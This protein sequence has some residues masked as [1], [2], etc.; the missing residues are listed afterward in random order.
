VSLPGHQGRVACLAVSADGRTLVSAAWDKTIRVWDVQPPKERRTITTPYPD[1]YRMVLAP[2]DKTV[3]IPGYQAV[4]RWSLESGEPLP[5]WKEFDRDVYGLAASPDRTVVAIGTSEQ[6]D[7]GERRSVSVGGRTIDSPVIAL[8]ERYALCDASTG[9]VKSRLQG[10]REMPIGV[11]FVGDGKRLASAT[12]KDLTVWD[13]TAGQPGPTVRA[14][15][16]GIL[17]LTGTADGTILATGGRDRTVKLWDP[18]AKALATLTGQKTVVGQVA[19]S[20]D[21]R[22]LAAATGDVLG[23]DLEALQD[24]VRI[25]DV[26]KKEPLVVFVGQRG[27]M[28]SAVFTNDGKTVIT[29]GQDGVI[30]FW[31]VP[32]PDSAPART[33]S[34]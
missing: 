5:S 7:T 20:R 11:A 26:S 29:G 31:D 16:R 33:P 6:V 9:K 34:G 28:T 23:N 27:W 18:S 1:V 10:T 25:W 21:G 22:L 2:D 13:L 15:D 17:W 4:H 3:V 30:R 24:E 12:G 19:F 32:A 14:H 8:R